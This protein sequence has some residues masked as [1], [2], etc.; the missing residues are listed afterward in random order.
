[1]VPVSIYGESGQYLPGSENL[2]GKIIAIKCNHYSSLCF[3]S[4][5]DYPSGIF[6]FPSRNFFRTT[7]YLEQLFLPTFSEWLL[8]HN[9]YFFR[10]AIS[11]EQRFFFSFFRTVTFLQQLFFQNSIFFRTKLLQSSHFLRIGCSLWQLLY[12]T[13][14]FLGGTV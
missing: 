11:S 1:M 13:D 9:S 12:G 8:R 3:F 2:S 7:L 4:N 6:V 5:S 14:I 10:E